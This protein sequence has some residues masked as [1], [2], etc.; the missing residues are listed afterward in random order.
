MLIKEQGVSIN[1][2]KNYTNVAADEDGIGGNGK[3]L[4]NNVEG[5]K[6]LTYFLSHYLAVK[7][8]VRLKSIESIKDL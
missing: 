3:D 4:K 7:T 2:R 1:N 8:D 5:A 6:M